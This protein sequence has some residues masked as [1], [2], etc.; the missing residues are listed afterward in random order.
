MPRRPR[1]CPPGIPQ[2]IIQRGNNRCPC[3]ASNADRAAYANWLREAAERYDVEIHAWVFMTNHVHL[4][5]TP[6]KEGGASKMM[7]YIGRLYVRYFN[8][9]YRRTGTLWEGRHKSCLVGHDAYLFHCYRYI[10]LNPVRAG[11]V[12]QPA[13]YVWSSYHSN[14]LGVESALRTPHSLYLQL[15]ATRCEREERYRDLFGTDIENR[16]AGEIRAATLQG[17]VFGDEAFRDS[18]AALTGQRV[19]LEK[20]GPKREL[21]V[22]CQ[23][24][25]FLL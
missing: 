21:L 7:Q 13:D 1:L 10:E 4:L 3:F 11:L 15:G 8:Q 23:A 5:V 19:R 12:Q 18:V 25:E 6:Q 9:K 16:A 24:Q 17:L 20:S 22:S 14:A 2:H